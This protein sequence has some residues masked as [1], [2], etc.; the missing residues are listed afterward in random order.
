MTSRR[1]LVIDASVAIKWYVP[2]DRSAAAVSLLESGDILLAPDLI[3]PEFG[4]IIWKKVQRGELT[5]DEGR[6]IV[7]AFTSLTLLSHIP[8]VRLLPGALEIALSFDR[9]VY[10]SL[11]L[12]LAVTAD[13]LFITADE[14]LVRALAGTELGDTVRVL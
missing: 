7:N 12:A 4:N 10:D 2:E 5:A 1:R 8:S 3:V 11:Y 13:A 9:S 6:S 14:R